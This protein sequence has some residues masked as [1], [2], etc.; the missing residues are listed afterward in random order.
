MYTEH[1]GQNLRRAPQNDTDFFFLIFLIIYKK[2]FNFFKK[3][4]KWRYWCVIKGINKLPDWD[5]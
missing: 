1:P 2:I 4:D 5:W 3:F